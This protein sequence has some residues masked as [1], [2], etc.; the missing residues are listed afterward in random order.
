MSAIT[1]S[2]SD[3][4]L[5]PRHT[6]LALGRLRL[7]IG[8]ALVT[9]YRRSLFVLVE[10]T[11]GVHDLMTVACDRYRYF[12]DYGSE[13]HPNCLD[14]LAGALAPYGIT[15]P[16]VPENINL[17]QNTVLDNRGNMRIET[18]LSKAGDYVAMRCLID[19]VVAISACPQDFNPCNGFNPTELAVRVVGL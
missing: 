14:N 15:K 1:L 17:F 12:V 16:Y 6:R 2:D 18:P 7:G 5:S 4:F 11:V 9:N 19:S 13:G 10:D 8:D 3:E